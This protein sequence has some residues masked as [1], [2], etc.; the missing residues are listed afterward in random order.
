MQLCIKIVSDW[1]DSLMVL[2]LPNRTINWPQLK[3]EFH[4]PSKG[5]KKKTENK[6]TNWKENQDGY[7]IKFHGNAFVLIVSIYT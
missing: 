4:H 5:K 3:M 7:E 1:L 2:S 6:I